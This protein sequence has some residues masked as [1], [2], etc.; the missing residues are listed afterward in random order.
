MVDAKR[1]ITREELLSPSDY[2]VIRRARKAELARH[3]LIRRV[4]V[5][6]DV[7]ITFES[8]QT[9]W[10]QI[11]EML[12]IEKGG[13]SQIEDEL[14]AYASLVPN[15][16]ELVAT[17]MFEIDEPIRRAAILGRLGGVEATVH[18]QFEGETIAACPETDIERTTTDGK[19]SSVHFLH[20]PF[21]AGQ[22]ARFRFPETRVVLGIGHPR[23]G[24]LAVLPEATRS[25]L[26]ADLDGP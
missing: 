20:F 11:H 14:R 12:Y 26:A 16:R 9:V 7:A 22:I 17:L 13:D 5:G 15:G 10:M 21:N 3:K 25:V 24:H 6:P 4:P 18:F 1:R 2:A 23:Y 8:Y 19:T